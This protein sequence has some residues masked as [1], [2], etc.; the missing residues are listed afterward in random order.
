MNDRK[1]S[2][3]DVLLATT[4]VGGIAALLLSPSRTMAAMSQQTL[5][6]SSE[7]GIAYANRC[8]VNAVDGQHAKIFNQ[9]QA[10]LASQSA[11]DG[12]VLTQTAVCPI[13][14]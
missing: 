10:L 8:S 11:S 5:S 13:C 12:Q 3:R 9:L 14:G 2:R 6:G 1:V 7:L 4:G